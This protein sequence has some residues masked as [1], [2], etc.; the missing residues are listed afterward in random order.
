MTPRSVFLGVDPEW[1]ERSL[2]GESCRSCGGL[3]VLNES[4]GYYEGAGFH[5]IACPDCYETGY[6]LPVPESIVVPEQLHQGDVVWIVTLE[7][8]EE[9]DE[10]PEGYICQDHQIDGFA[11]VVVASTTVTADAVMHATFPEVGQWKDDPSLWLV[12][13][14]PLV[15]CDPQTEIECGRCPDGPDPDFWAGGLF[16]GDCCNGSGSIPVPALAPGE[17]KAL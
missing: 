16:L 17:V 12:Q 13:L 4:D 1:I 15:P 7:S 11:S 9:C 3:G 8:C 14:A 2:T 6:V 5:Q 10:L